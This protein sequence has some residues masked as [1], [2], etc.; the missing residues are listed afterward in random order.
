MNQKR[1][2][3]FY[4]N[5]VLCLSCSISNVNKPDYSNRLKTLRPVTTG[6][7]EIA[8]TVTKETIHQF[9]TLTV[10]VLRKSS[11]PK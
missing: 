1:F 10:P 8:I 5:M 9:T 7:D 2:D 11:L 6:N 4:Y 3:V